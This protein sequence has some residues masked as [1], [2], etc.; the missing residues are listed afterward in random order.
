MQ[1]HFKKFDFSN[2]KEEEITDFKPEWLNDEEQMQKYFVWQN[3]QTW[4]IDLL[5]DYLDI[6]CETNNIMVLEM[7]F[8]ATYFFSS[9]QAV[10]NYGY[11][12]RLTAQKS[13]FD[14]FMHCFWCAMNYP[15]YYRPSGIDVFSLLNYCEIKDP[16]ISDFLMKLRPCL[17]AGTLP[18]CPD[19][20]DLNVYEDSI[21][22]FPEW[23][24]KIE[25]YRDIIRQYS[26]PKWKSAR[27]KK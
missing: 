25:L 1:A 11:F 27:M 18:F 16:E 21:A 13:N 6:I 19:D 26:V 7:I 8:Q 22:I 17:V 14:T 4:R 12:L 10:V 3:R 9:S 24:E 5:V 15:K 20:K 23:I 2:V